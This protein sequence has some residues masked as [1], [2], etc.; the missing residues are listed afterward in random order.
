MEPEASEVSGR[1]PWQFGNVEQPKKASAVSRLRRMTIG[2]PQS[3]HGRPTSLSRCAIPTP[4][5]R[6]LVTINTECT[7]VADQ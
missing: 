5:P 7:A 4:L 1:V 6:E 3:G 2:A